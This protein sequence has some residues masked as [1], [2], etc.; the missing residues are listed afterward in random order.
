MAS[1]VRAIERVWYPLMK[2]HEQRQPQLN[3]IRR[4][5]NGVIVV[6]E[7]EIFAPC[8]VA[9]GILHTDWIDAPAA[10]TLESLSILW[11]LQP[12]ILLLGSDARP[13]G[14]REIRQQLAARD[15]S[16][17]SMDLGAACRTYNVL[18]AEDR[19][20]AAL[21]FPGGI[22]HVTQSLVS[23]S[24]LFACFLLAA[25]SRPSP[26]PVRRH[27]APAAVDAARLVAADRE[28]GQWMTHGRTYDEQ[29]YSP[30]DQVNDQNV[31][32]PRA[33]VALRPGRNRARPVH[34]LP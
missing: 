22:S 18:A 27:F 6:E 10:L 33:R 9:P 16:L 34:P 21:L 3:L 5:G 13:A 32:R 26:S 20:V 19:P 31:N 11:P 23:R 7:R 24:A 14:L 30:L 8:V 25:C 4:Y 17:E 12:R 1:I 2:L 15:I 29:R 28:P